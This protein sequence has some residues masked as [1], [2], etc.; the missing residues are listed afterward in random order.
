MTEG[1]IQQ[2]ELPPETKDV[3]TL[4]LEANPSYRGSL[5]IPAILLIAAGL[6]VPFD[7]SVASSISSNKDSWPKWVSEL[8]S[9]SEA[10]G[11]GI[12]ATLVIIAV[13]ALD[14]ARRPAMGTLCAASLGGGLVANLGKLA[15][16]RT[17]PRSYDLAIGSGW[18]SFG[19]LFPGNIG[20]AEQSFPSAHTSTA[21]GLAV[22]LSTW[23]PQGKWYFATLAILVGLQR[24]YCLAHYPSDVLAGAALGWLIAKICLAATNK[25]RSRTE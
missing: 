11:H 13:W 22:I 10:F 2:H 16:A 20:S 17:R 7:V 24:M 15:I 1:S 6:A 5:L 4:A 25:T 9:N 14:S 23:Y 21:V 19:Q 18:E 12:G 3:S 8:M